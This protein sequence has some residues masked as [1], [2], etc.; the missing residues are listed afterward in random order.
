M[1]RLHISLFGKFCV[2]C[3]Q[4]LINFEGQKLQELFCY[5]LLHRE[6][7]HHRETLANLLWSD[8]TNKRSRDYLRKTLWQ[9]Q[10]TIR[11]QTDSSQ[12]D[13]LLTESDWIQI[14]P[15]ANIWLDVAVFEEAS[16]LIQ[17]LFGQEL[18]S[19]NVK[20]LQY[21]TNL[22][23]GDLLDGWYQEWCLY[24]RERFHHMF[25]NMLDKLMDYCEIHCDYETGLTYCGRVLNYDIAN[26]RT[27]RRVMRLNY[28]KGNRTE[29]LRQYEFCQ[30]ALDEELG[31]KPSQKTKI[32]YEQIKD[33]AVFDVI[34]Q[35]NANKLTPPLEPVPQGE[36]IQQ[37]QQ[38]Q[39]DLTL[40]E[41]QLQQKIEG[42]NQILKNFKSAS[43][44]GHDNN[45][46]E[47]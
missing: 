34:S 44:P 14:N 4:V 9:L 40:I 5:L 15:A 20:K 24:E 47:G 31:V 22:Y 32:L 45:S 37:L 42:V 39:Q 12:Y 43:D 41:L 11:K 3:N 8:V 28:L 36:I 1:N 38:L 27:H 6:R 17:G 29:A 35:S 21:A 2:Q 30:K 10:T 46:L 16:N 7:P 23:Q 19:P 33:D 13:L 25:L 26:E 18:K